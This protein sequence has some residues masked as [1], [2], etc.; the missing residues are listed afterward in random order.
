MPPLNRF[1]KMAVIAGVESA[2]R[3]HIDR[4][5]DLNARDGNGLTLLMLSAARN[6]SAIC[7]LLIDAGADRDVLDPSGKTAYAIAVAAGAR[8]ASD[9][10]SPA[11]TPLEDFD[12]QAP[13]IELASNGPNVPLGGH[14]SERPVYINDKNTNNADQTTP[15]TQVDTEEVTELE[16]MPEFDLFGWEPEEDAPPPEAD[17]SVVQAASAIQTAISK[18][19]PVDSSEDW[20]DIDV[21]LPERSMPLVRLD[22][23]ETRERLRLLLLRAAREGSVP[24]MAVE[25]LSRNDD[26]SENLEAEAV[27][28]MVINDLGAEIDERFEYA[29]SNENFEVFVNPEETLDEEEIIGSALGFIDNIASSRTDPLRLYQKEFQRERRIS[30]AEEVSLAQAMEF[31]LERALDALANWP[32]G[33]RL[34]LAAGHLVKTRQEPLTWLS[35]VPVEIQPDIESTIISTSNHDV[36]TTDQTDEEVEPVNESR[37]DTEL[38]LGNHEAIF[39]DALSRLSNLSVDSGQQGE[40]W[41]AIRETLSSL[42]L[43]RRFLLE[44]TDVEHDDGNSLSGANYVTAMMAYQCARERMVAANLKLVFHHAKKYLFSNEPLDDLAQEGNI[45]LLKAVD[46]FDWRRGFKFSTFATW[47]IRQQIGR[48]VADKCSTIRIPVHMY[49]SAQRLSREIQ[50]FESE[51]GRAPDL[52]EIAVRLDMPVRKIAALQRLAPEPLPI[53]EIPI[54]E[55]IAVDAQSDFASPD[56]FDI[57][58]KSELREAM[59]KVLSTLKPKEEQIIRLRFGIGIKDSLTLEDIGQ[60][61]EVTRERVRQIEAGAIRK[62]QQPSKINLLSLVFFGTTFTKK[63]NGEEN[64]SEPEINERIS[65]ATPIQ[66]PVQISS[67]PTKSGSLS[68]TKSP[69][70]DRLLEQAAGLGIPIIDDRKGTS[71]KIWINFIEAHDSHYRQLVRKLLAFGFEF[72]PGKGFFR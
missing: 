3:I 6:N 15:I 49:D 43:N 57:A 35:I 41:H 33:I 36:E 5:D 54:D 70:I 45:G 24:H 66:R 62:M 23:V 40:N 25:D 44:L 67:T 1:L 12:A 13:I 2:I 55:L 10:L 26:L 48:Y 31:E 47:W 65:E 63:N 46:R 39:L 28:S 20:D 64:S 21:Y 22:D 42:Q 17:S 4:G 14:I 71:G 58:S 51:T 52:D 16:K 69:G 11:I 56:P 8:E 27:L 37:F 19:E 30:G 50:A 7:K 61:Y 9:I 72:L 53:H 59:I 60:R 32:Q 38:P 29:N 34:T 18:Y 68:P